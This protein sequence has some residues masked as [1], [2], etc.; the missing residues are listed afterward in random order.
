M[1]LLGYGHLGDSELKEFRVTYCTEPP[2]KGADAPRSQNAVALA[3]LKQ[4]K[5]LFLLLYKL[6]GQLRDFAGLWAPVRL[7]M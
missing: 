5:A 7:R 1:T 3:T 6:K 4:K 2:S